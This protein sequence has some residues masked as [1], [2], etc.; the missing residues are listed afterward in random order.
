MKILALFNQKGGVGKTTSTINIGAGLVRLGKEVLLIDFDPQASLTYSLGIEAHELKNT[1]YQVLRQE[2]LPQEALICKDGITLLPASI[3]LS[4]FE[5]DS[6]D[7]TQQKFMLKN[8]IP[9]LNEFEYV[10]I[11]CPPSLGLLTLNVM[12]AADQ[13]LIPVQTEFLA[14]HGL[15]QLIDTFTL[16]TKKINPHLKLGGIIATRY[17]RRK[18]NKDVI[19]C[20]QDSF[21]DKLFKTIIRENVSLTEAP[22]FGQD[23]YTYN[24]ESHGAE[25]YL[26]LSKE[27]C[28]I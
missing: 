24:P 22:S 6:V 28:A 3:E 27:V 12:A 21:K 25:D 18:I 9:Q 14:L 16:I 17:N 1:I 13:V 4:A 20:L 19:T 5:V 10:V 2:V 23:I 11:D 7:K 8:I 15:S 26:S